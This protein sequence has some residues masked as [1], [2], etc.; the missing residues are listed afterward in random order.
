[1]HRHRFSTTNKQ[2]ESRYQNFIVGYLRTNP[3]LSQ[4]H[5]DDLAAKV[6][7]TTSDLMEWYK[8]ARGNQKPPLSYYMRQSAG[9]LKNQLSELGLLT[10]GFK[11]AL[12]YRLFLANSSPERL[13]EQQRIAKSVKQRQQ[14]RHVKRRNWEAFFSGLTEQDYEVFRIVWDGP[15]KLEAQCLVNEVPFDSNKSLK[16]NAIVFVKSKHPNYEPHKDIDEAA[17]LYF[18]DNPGVELRDKVD[19]LSNKFPILRFMSRTSPDLGRSYARFTGFQ[20][21]FD[22]VYLL[23]L[24]KLVQRN[25][26]SSLLEAFPQLNL[27]PYSDKLMMGHT[28]VEHCFPLEYNRQIIHVQAFYN[29]SLRDPESVLCKIYDL[30]IELPEYCTLVQA[31]NLLAEKLDISCENQ[32]E[33]L[34]VEFHSLVSYLTGHRGKLRPMVLKFYSEISGL[35]YD[36][37]TTE[38]FT[39][40]I[41]ALGMPKFVAKPTQ[42]PQFDFVQ[43]Y[44]EQAETAALEVE[45]D[46]E[47]VELVTSGEI[48]A[49]PRGNV[50]DVKTDGELAIGRI[51]TIGT[52]EFEV[53]SCVSEENHIYRCIAFENIREEISMDEPVSFSS[54]PFLH[55]RLED[56]RGKTVTSL[57][58]I[59]EQDL[60]NESK[61]PPR[62]IRSQSNLKQEQKTGRH[63]GELAAYGVI[64]TDTPT[65]DCLYPL[66]DS[67]IH[68][69][70]TTHN[71]ILKNWIESLTMRIARHRPIVFGRFYPSEATCNELGPRLR[72]EETN[73]IT[74]SAS[75]YSD[76]P[77]AKW[78]VVDSSVALA[79]QDSRSVLVLPNTNHINQAIN[80]L[81]SKMGA[82][83]HPNLFT[84]Y[85][86]HIPLQIRLGEKT[87]KPSACANFPFIYGIPYQRQ[88]TT[89]LGVC[90]DELE[91]PY[92][93]SMFDWASS[94]WVLKE[95]EMTGR[96]YVDPHLSGSRALNNNK[97]SANELADILVCRERWELGAQL[98]GIKNSEFSRS[99]NL[100]L[101]PEHE[102]FL[103]SV[104]APMVDFFEQ[105]ELR[106]VLKVVSSLQSEREEVTD[107]SWAQWLELDKQ[108]QDASESESESDNEFDWND[109]FDDSE[110]K[111]EKEDEK[112]S[113]EETDE[114][115]IDDDSDFE[116]D[117]FLDLD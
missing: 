37:N 46:E 101:N 111:P 61:P 2:P 15:A 103:S 34:E 50:V 85:L 10:S 97:V 17:A 113:Q 26:K 76:S 40:M 87:I 44:D 30:G 64:P 80:E 95:D 43:T 54:Y 96:I 16:E 93:F 28:I 86:G 9:D 107:Q 70:V 32:E 78:H 115:R 55:P 98:Q 19:P 81:Y 13:D 94:V 6:G 92:A 88:F 112:Q 49:I 7:M 110:K 18:G 36:G 84:S 104:H 100:P 69:A 52:H 90:L 22:I 65:I 3:A 60:F 71:G 31:I 56:V 82:A 12:A 47:E 23:H 79:S 106:D 5:I 57:G 11:K 39:G 66:I 33:V 91:I 105:D 29:T 35:T 20:A 83:S 27:N 51:A 72:R 108:T 1:M 73:D 58:R 42:A 14:A 45:S 48:F 63:H 114:I 102:T 117:D 89:V 99:Q 41:R 75:L 4:K 62:V 24:V 68:V 116:D 59:V 53:M 21:K 77:L 67:G 25:E 8:K 74:I 38:F 109:V